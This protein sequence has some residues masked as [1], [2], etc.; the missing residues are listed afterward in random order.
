VTTGGDISVADLEGLI[1]GRTTL[2]MSF[3]E[4]TAEEATAALAKSSG[5]RF[6]PPQASPWDRVVSPAPAGDGSSEN[7]PRYNAEVVKMD[8]WPA[9]RAWSRAEAA[10]MKREREALQRRQSEDKPPTMAVA[11]GETPTPEALA[12]WQAE[13]AAWSRRQAQQLQRFNSQGLSVQFDSSAQLWSLSQRD[14]LGTG[15]AVNFWPCLVLATDFRRSQNLSITEDEPQ[16]KAAGNAAGTPTGTAA[17]KVTDKAAPLKAP[18]QAPAAMGAEA[19]EGGQLNDALSLN[20]S[21]YVD[22]KLLERAKVRLQVREA[23]DDAG[24][25]L[26]PER[27][28]EAWRTL[29][30]PMNAG[31]PYS[32]RSGMD[33]QIALRPRQSKGQK[34]G[35]LRGVVQIYYPMQTKTHEITD[36]GGPQG[37]VIG[38]G[39]L[40][41]P[42]QFQPPRLENG[43]WKSG[44]SLTFKSN[45]GGRAVQRNLQNRTRWDEVGEGVLGRLL[46]PGSYTLT[47]SQ[48]RT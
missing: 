34:L 22:P 33:S 13:Q 27:A 35:L 15:R 47:D 5:L 21:V 29:K 23:R 25:D 6:G 39:D 3:Q 4:L 28:K 48:G 31:D 37:F 44:A 16:Q 12:A 38:T 41:A 36:L 40:P 7:V 42:A 10:R 45:R 32:Q 14:Q 17:D 30:G 43:R 9:V 1:G 19:V 2:E 18:L 11:A 46:L 26:L 8:F 20:L 24:E